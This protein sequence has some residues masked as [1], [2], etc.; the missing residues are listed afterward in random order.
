MRRWRRGAARAVPFGA[1]APRAGAR[2]G[3]RRCHIPPTSPRSVSYPLQS[4]SLP[5][6]RVSVVT[7]SGHR[8]PLPPPRRS[9]PPS[10]GVTSSRCLSPFR[11]FRP[12]AVGATQPSASL[13]GPLS[14]PVAPPPRAPRGPD[15]A[16]AGG[17][18]ASPSAPSGPPLQSL[19]LSPHHYPPHPL[20]TPVRNG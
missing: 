6:P 12:H 13:R 20:P 5:V 10:V 8:S 1:A 2:S 15:A 7:R 9:H 11:P 4:V 19:G 3:R 18:S 17:G 16:P 14:R